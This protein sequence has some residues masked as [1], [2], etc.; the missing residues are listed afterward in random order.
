MTLKTSTT[1]TPAPV[2]TNSEEL[3][4]IVAFGNSLTAGFGLPED[5]KFPALLQ[6]KLDAKGL[7]YQVINAGISGDTSAGGV[8]RIDWSLQ[9]NVKFLIL[10]LGAND[11]LRG[12]PVAETKKNLSQIIERARA[13]GVTVV[14]AGM[15]APPN[16]GEAYTRSFR[17]IYRELADKYQLA[18]IPFVLEGVGGMADL[19]QPDGIHPN[20]EGERVM[21]EN[22]WRVLE[23]EIAK[24]AK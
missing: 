4:V 1:P 21:T 18:F 24:H 11:A 23:G 22:V 2:S 20:A 16:M 6:R 12:Q 7:R 14:L 8:R 19:N 10:E 3:P 17:Q 9:G 5:Q 13:R 15:E